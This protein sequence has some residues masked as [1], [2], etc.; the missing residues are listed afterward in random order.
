MRFASLSIFL[1]KIDAINGRFALGSIAL[2]LFHRSGTACRHSI[3]RMAFSH[4]QLGKTGEALFWL[5]TL[6][7]LLRRWLISTKTRRL[8]VI[9]LARPELRRVDG[10]LRL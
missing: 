5:P 3:E 1:F 2:T 8:G 4:Y 7:V 6:A 9:S 10:I